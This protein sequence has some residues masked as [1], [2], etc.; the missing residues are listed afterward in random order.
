MTS[1]G[2]PPLCSGP[3][4]VR[5]PK[6]GIFSAAGAEGAHVGRR[7]GSPRGGHRG[8]VSLGEMLTSL[9][10]TLH[11][12]LRERPGP[13]SPCPHRVSPS[14]SAPTWMPAWGAQAGG[15]RRRVKLPCSALCSSTQPGSL[16]GAW[17]GGTRRPPHL[18]CQHCPSSHQGSTE[19]PSDPWLW[20][21]QQSPGLPESKLP[22]CSP[23]P[24]R[25]GECASVYVCM[26]MCAPV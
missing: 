2:P 20:A 5:R 4:E 14:H 18:I 12:P 10:D 23:F 6:H 7:P 8:I 24:S 16:E 19:V 13:Q 9:Q 25:G 22:A 21:H 3:G 11:E 1:L 15:S 17:D 26:C